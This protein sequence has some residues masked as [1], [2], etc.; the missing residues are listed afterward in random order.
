MKKII[1]I[2]GGI[3]GLSAGC[4]ARMNGYQAHIFEMHT[5]PGGLCT[6]W[7]RNG[8][9]FDGSIHWLEGTSPSHP[10]YEIWQE[11]GAL[12]DKQIY[13]KEMSY[14]IFLKDQVIML[15]N[16]P[17]RLKQYLCALAPED[18]AMIHEL[19][20]SIGLFYPFQEMP[21]SKPKE[22]F[23]LFDKIREI[24]NYF[25][26]IRLMQKYGKMTVDEFTGRF[27]NPVLR[28]AIRATIETTAT[29][30]DSINGFVGVLFVLATRGSGFPEGGSLALAQSIEQRYVGLGG[31]IQY[32]AKVKKIL[33]ENNTAIGIQLEDGRE[34]TADLVISAADGY[35]NRKIK[36]C[37]E[38]EAV[39]P[40]TVQVSIGVA[41]DVSEMA[42]PHAIF[43]MYPLKQPIIVAGQANHLLRIKNYSFDPS[44][45]P[46]G[47]S[48]LVVIFGS[49]SADWETIY[50]DQEK[51]REEKHRIKQDVLSCLEEIR[52]GIKEKI[53][54]VDVATPMT[55]IRYT[56]TW[57]GSPMGFAKNILLN[58]PRTLPGLKNFFMVGQWVG[59]MGVSGAAKSGRDIVQLICK[60][61]KKGFMT[62]KA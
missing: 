51:Y 28:E 2:G 39:T 17:E 58:L 30:N 35:L 41:M 27:K 22:F 54:V 4:Y 31:K 18:R 12:K 19:A 23:T 49:D 24:K 40:S 10:F 53:E 11:L 13:Y 45:A 6:S 15:Y 7:K 55:Y 38:K 44:F 5:L 20:N 50:A 1:I 16:D 9:T 62:A 43:S 52:P 3:S 60:Q 37:Y 29:D 46:E 14:K 56:N 48:T 59:D 61:D 21:L 25:A 57:K 26:I 47:K 8:Y 42:D 32:G 33:V 36:H 34:E